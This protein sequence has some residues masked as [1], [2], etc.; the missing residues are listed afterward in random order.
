MRDAQNMALVAPSE[1]SYVHGGYGQLFDK[2][3]RALEGRQAGDA[4]QLQLEPEEA[5][6]EYDPELVRLEKAERYGEGVTAGMEV[7][8]DERIYRVTD[9]AAGRVVLDGNHPL[10][11]IALRFSVVI[12]AVR[13][14]TQEEVSRAVSLP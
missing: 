8:E 11:G 3:E 14:A 1:L 7:E 13:P 12:L 4:L 9:V 2:L 6:G 5:F 10:A